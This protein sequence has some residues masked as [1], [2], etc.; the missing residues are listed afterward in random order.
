MIPYKLEIGAHCDSHSESE[1][2]SIT[3]ESSFYQNQESSDRGGT[4]PK[5]KLTKL[6]SI[7]LSRLP[8]L[9]SSTRRAKSRFDRLPIILAADAPSSGQSTPSYMKATSSS[10]ARK[11]RLQNSET[12]STRRSSGRNLTRMSSLKFKRPLMS[13]SSSG[14]EMQRKLKKSRSIKLSSFEGSS[15]STRSVEYRYQASPRSSESSFSSNHYVRKK[16]SAPNPKSV[17]SGNKSVRAITRTSSLKPVKILTKM[18]TF[19][20]KRPS[21][22]KCSETCQFPDTSKHKATCSSTLKDSK[23]PKSLEIQPGERESAGVSVMKVCPYT[24]C[25]LHGH[26]RDALPPLKR[27]VSMRRRMLK[28]QKSMRQESRSSLRAKLPGNQKKGIRASQM[29]QNGD[30]AV[31]KT[32]RV[33]RANSQV[34]KNSVV[35]SASDCEPLEEQITGS[36]EK[37][38]SLEPDYESLQEF[39]PHKDCKP[40]STNTVAYKVQFKNQKYIRMWHLIYKHAVVGIKANGENQ[41][42]LDGLQKEVEDGNTLLETNCSPQGC[43]EMDQHKGMEN[44]DAD[45]QQNELRQIDAIKLVQAAFDDILLPEFQDH[46]SDDQSITS[47]ISSDQELLKESRGEGGKQSLSAS[48]DPAKDSM[49]Q[50]PEDKWLKANKT[51]TSKEEKTAANMGNKSAQKLPKSWSKLKKII[52]LKRFVKAL[53]K[54]RNFNPRRPRYLS[55]EPDSEAAKVH[56]RHKTTDERKNTEEWMLDYALRDVISKLAPAQKRKV[57]L[58]VEA[59]ETVVP[60]PDAKTNLRSNAVVSNQENPVQ[61][62]NGSS[63]QSGEEI[64]QENDYDNSAEIMSGITT[65]PEKIFKE[66]PEKVSN[67]LATEQQSPL[68]LSQLRERSWGRCCI[69]TEKDIPASEDWKEKQ[70]VDICRGVDNKL[71]VADDQPDSI[72]ICSPEIKDPSICDKLSLNPEDSI[73]TCHEEVQVNGEVQEKITSSSELWNSDSESDGQHMET[74]TLI[75]V[76]HEQ[77]DTYKS[78]TPENYAE[79]QANT[80]VVASAYNC[81]LLEEPTKIQKDRNGEAKPESRFSQLE[82]SDPNITNHVVDDT[83]LEK[84]RNMRLWYLVYKHMVS[85]IAA[86]DGTK[87]LDRADEEEKVDQANSL[88]STSIPSSCQNFSKMDTDMDMDHDADGQKVEFDHIEAIKMVEEAIDEIH[89][90]ETQDHSPDDQSNSSDVIPDEELSEKKLGEG[91]EPLTSTSTSLARDSFRESDKTEPE[92]RTVLDTEQNW[93]ISDNISTQEEEKKV[94]NVGK[95][96]TQQMPSNWSHL[97]KLILLKRFIKALEKVRKFNPRGPRYLPLEPD[98]EA[99]KVNLRH[100]DMDGR[101]NAEEWMLDYAL[102]QVVAKLTPARKRK[103]E[104]LVQ[105]FETVIPTIGS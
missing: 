99:E 21:A 15:P 85:G 3:N 71:I 49:V 19:K 91:G 90:P 6:R 14:T 62:C 7:K 96:S 88:P 66:H 26:H 20:S 10:S 5:K 94:L 9:R 67:V 72:I 31:R 101:K 69:K 93:L 78:S 83:R 34:K 25:S 84:R 75:S 33:S 52:L 98:P 30:P 92:Y 73:R 12:V 18:A 17:S 13:K 102:Q 55:L 104:L 63:V 86:T 39:P 81:D 2:L 74:N 32:T 95:K 35:S 50:D 46:S 77:S 100:L 105:A 82:G 80:H 59:F 36:E 58:L 1:T 57:A 38:R 27:F 24:Y 54:V 51:S 79:S 70:I 42:P 68:N 16:S 47:A 8:S 44:H 61:A 43:S 28:T 65:Y 64:G 45:H 29:D 4:E 22:G 48:S 97:K 89:L 37:S 76:P 53:E 103:V 23:F 41:L 60:L 56:L 87:A 40:D 11:E